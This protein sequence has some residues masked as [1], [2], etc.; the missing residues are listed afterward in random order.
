MSNLAGSEI[1][2]VGMSTAQ[3]TA[4]AALRAG[5]SFQQAGVN[6]A[7]VCRWVPRDAAFRAAYNAWQG[8]L[9]G[10]SRWPPQVGG[11]GPC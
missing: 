1:Q 9:G 3:E 10:T 4:L 2:V 5:S 11:S 7:S 8:E 6:R